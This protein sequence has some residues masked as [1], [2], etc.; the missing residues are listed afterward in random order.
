MAR[1]AGRTCSRSKNKLPSA[2]TAFAARWRR[3]QQCWVGES[4]HAKRASS[5]TPRHHAT[6]LPEFDVTVLTVRSGTQTFR[7]QADDA[8]AA[9]SAIE[10]DLREGCSHCPADWCTDDV[11]S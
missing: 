11:Q 10:S 1:P 9:R 8:T 2:H 7:I 3:C 5:S 4:G 6:T